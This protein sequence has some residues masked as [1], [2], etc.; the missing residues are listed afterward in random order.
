MMKEEEKEEWKWLEEQREG[1][2]HSLLRKFKV[3]L[4]YRASSRQA[5]VLGHIDRPSLSTKNIQKF[6]TYGA[7]RTYL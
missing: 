5:P 1:E 7:Y 6:N 2:K 4:S 3:S